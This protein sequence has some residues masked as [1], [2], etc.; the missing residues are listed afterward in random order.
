MRS[1]LTDSLETL[2]SSFTLALLFDL[3][4]KPDVLEPEQQNEQKQEA[5]LCR[6]A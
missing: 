4:V 6:V 3:R 2:S 5:E 1:C